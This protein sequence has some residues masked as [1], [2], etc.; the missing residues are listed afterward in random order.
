[1]GGPRFFASVQRRAI[2]VAPLFPVADD[3]GVDERRQRLGMRRRRAAGDDQR[4]VLAARA[5]SK[6]DAPRS[7]MRRTLV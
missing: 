3:D 6:R 7:S 4:I 2:S 1:V 5:G